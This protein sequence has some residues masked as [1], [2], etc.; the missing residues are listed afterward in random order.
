MAANKPSWTGTWDCGVPVNR[1]VLTQSGGSLSGTYTGV[2]PP[3]NWGGKTAYDGRISGTI[4]YT[5]QF[6]LGRFEG[7]WADVGTAEND[8]T[9]GPEKGRT[10][11]LTMQMF[12]YEGRNVIGMAHS[13]W[14]NN[15]CRA[16]STSPG[17]TTPPTTTTK[18]P[19]TTPEDTT[20]P[21]V[22]A[23][24]PA[25]VTK[26]KTSVAL[27]FNVTDDSGRASALATL[28]DGGAKIR[29]AGGTGPAT[30]KGWQWKVELAAGLKGPLFFCVWAKD[31]AGNRSAKSPKSSCAWI[32]LLVDIERVSNG[33]G[34]EGWSG[35]V[36]A[37]NWAGNTGSYSQGGTTYVVNF[38]AACNLHDAGYGGHT[39]E[40]GIN[41]GVVDFRRWS[42][43]QVDRKFR[44]DMARLCAAQIPASAP[45]ALSECRGNWRNQFVRKFGS[46]FFDADLMT[47]GTQT[48][49]FRDN[50]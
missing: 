8:N 25:G 42:R 5:K 17:T 39:V 29:S 9:L 30:G 45:A 1:M 14:G 36:A 43:K 4:T 47:P 31:A 6:E 19:A 12:V 40:D 49:G 38:V 44:D 15:M 2:A 20:P 10:G 13:R 26:P 16:T 46:R 28:Y 35:I 21:Q 24:S 50:S 11:T 37:Q 33:C 41:G 23:L 34:G 18:P 48:D 3:A 32:P 27:D 22:K 7:T